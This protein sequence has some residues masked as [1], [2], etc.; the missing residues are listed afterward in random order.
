L[1]EALEVEGLIAQARGDVEHAKRAFQ[2]W[3]DGG[4]DDASVEER[5][6]ALL[7]R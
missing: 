1:P 7:N 6:R 5:A 4:A 3:L 2:Q